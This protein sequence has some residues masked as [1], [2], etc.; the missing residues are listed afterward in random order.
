MD[1]GGGVPCAGWFKGGDGAI[2]VVRFVSKV[3][4][5]SVVSGESL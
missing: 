5:E 2:C 4:S 1:A 3:V